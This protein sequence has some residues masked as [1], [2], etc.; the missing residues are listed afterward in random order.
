M[1][2]TKVYAFIFL[3]IAGAVAAAPPPPNYSQPPEECMP[4]FQELNECISFLVAHDSVIGA[5]T[6]G[7]CSALRD[8][9]RSPADVCLCHAIGND[10]SESLLTHVDPIRVA[11]L[12]LLCTTYLPPTLLIKCF[13][14]PVPPITR[15]RPP[16][17]SP[18]RN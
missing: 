3:L 8:V 18:T 5:P 2:I 7:C 9:V 16:S 11:I 10:L 13:L 12:P 14:G 17:S 15:P 4:T 6:S 1:A